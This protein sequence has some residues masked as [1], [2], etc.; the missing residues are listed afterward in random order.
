MIKTAAKAI[1]MI[2]QVKA[3]NE[4]IAI[5]KAVRESAC[6]PELELLMWAAF[7]PYVQFGVTKR[8]KKFKCEPS[9]NYIDLQSALNGLRR[10]GKTD[11]GRCDFELFATQ[12]E[13]P[14]LLWKVVTKTLRIGMTAKNLNKAGFDIGEFTCMLAATNKDNSHGTMPFPA[15]LSPK[16]DGVR[17]LVFPG[18]QALGRS[19]KPVP[20][21]NIIDL[22]PDTKYVMD[23]EFYCHGVPFDEI[24]GVFR[25]KDAPVPKGYKFVVFN[26]FTE[27]EWHSQK[28]AE[29]HTYWDN[30]NRLDDIV[31]PFIAA[32]E[33]DTCE[34]PA[35]VDRLLSAYWEDGYEGGMLR[36]IDTPY[37]WKRCSLKDNCLIKLKKIDHLDAQI[38]G[39]T[40]GRAGSDMEGTLGALQVRID[41]GVEFEV[42]SGYSR[43]QRDEIW[44]NRENLIDEWI[45]CKYTELTESGMPR[46]PVIFQSIR[47][48]K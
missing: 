12:W 30:L 47:D 7:D 9:R 10:D 27:D 26:V 44:A 38:V 6:G 4:K 39:F 31:D 21:K 40:E 46:P 32:M 2:Q 5:A 37:M 16:M 25:S 36:G 28:L 34:T 43:A 48:S 3:T 22:L 15:I 24:S 35:D 18:K 20:N 14:E 41:S 29:G 11:Q 8:P 17:M 19:G 23:G 42:G 13:D 33:T 1:Y 45:R